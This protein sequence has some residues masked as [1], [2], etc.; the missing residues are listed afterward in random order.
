MVAFTFGRL[1]ACPLASRIQ[2]AA[3][4]DDAGVFKLFRLEFGEGAYL[5]DFLGKATRLDSA[6]KHA[7]QTVTRQHSRFLPRLSLYGHGR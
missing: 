1:E 5:H 6:V 4:R 3:I 7:G 2:M